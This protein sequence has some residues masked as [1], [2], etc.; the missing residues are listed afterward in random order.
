MNHWTSQV[1]AGKNVRQES[2]LISDDGINLVKM[3]TV[4]TWHF[5]SA[6]LPITKAMNNNTDEIPSPTKQMSA[7]LLFH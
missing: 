7:Q 5:G 3:I 4:P 1:A 2:V 6:F